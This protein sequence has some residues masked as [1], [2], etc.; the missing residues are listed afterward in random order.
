MY[1][2]AWSNGSPLPTGAG[3]GVKISV[4]DRDRFFERAWS[5]VTIELPRG[6]ATVRLSPSFWRTC[7]ELRSQ[8]IGRWL[9]DEGL[10]PWPKGHPPMLRI[11]PLGA[12]RFRLSR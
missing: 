5:E 6:T 7:T 11:G 8:A 12:G 2:T 10:A 3:Y 1:A 9:Q 4:P